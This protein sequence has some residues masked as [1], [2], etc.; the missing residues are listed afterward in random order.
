MLH[1]NAIWTEMIASGMHSSTQDPPN[2][3]MFERA[4]GDTPYKM[5]DQPSLSQTLMDAVTAIASALP[6]R[7]GSSSTVSGVGTIPAR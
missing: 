6:P 7:L 4:G 2:T 5:K 3:T 1:I